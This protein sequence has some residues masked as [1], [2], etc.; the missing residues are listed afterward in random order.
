M[1]SDD[2]RGN[3]HGT[4]R[5]PQP[6]L[7]DQGRIASARR[8]ASPLGEVEAREILIDALLREPASLVVLLNTDGGGDIGF[9]PLAL[10]L[11]GRIAEL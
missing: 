5:D 3:H 4:H 11:T 1:S 7:G 9:E 6:S 2:N 8:G 10:G